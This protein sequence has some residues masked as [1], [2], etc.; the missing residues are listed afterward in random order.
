MI[1]P[2]VLIVGLALAG[3]GYGVSARHIAGLGVWLLV[4]G[5]LALGTA[6][7]AAFARPFYWA[8][9]LLCGLALL[10]ALSSL[11]SGSMELSV[12]EADR[13]LVYLG[14]FL[15]AFLIAQTDERRQRFAEGIAIAVTLV[16][17]LGLASR[18]LPEILSVGN[19]L[20]AG[21]RLR[22]PLGYWNANG[23]MFGIA[24][25]LLLWSSRRS[26]FAALRWAAVAAMPAVLLALY[27]TYS[28]GGLLS[29]LIA[30]GCLLAL[31]RDRLWMLATLAIGAIGALPAVL[32]VQARRSL[33]DSIA[34]QAAVDQ[35]LTVLLILLAGTA[36][37]LALFAGLR[38]LERREGRLTGHA[39]RLSQSP[40]LL[41]RLAIAA[42]LIAIGVVIAVGGR[43]WNQFSSSDLQFPNQPEKHFGQLSGAGRHDFY[44]VAVDSFGEKPLL[45]HGAGTYEFSW[46]RLRSIDIP[47]HNAH[48]LY[49]EAFSELGLVGG[50]VV[51]GLFGALLWTGFGAWRAAT[52]SQRELCAALLAAMA[53]FA[54]GAAFDWFW[55][56]AALG[57]VFF[58]A[59]G[60]LV[61]VRCAQLSAGA[62]AR[63]KGD[64]RR[65]G[66]AVS[67]LILAWIAAIGLVGPLLVQH[68]LKSSQ[69][70]AADGDLASAVSHA[71]TARSIEPWAASPYVQ[72]GLLAQLQGEFPVASERL[73]QA[74]ERE[75]RNWQLYYLRSKVEHEAGEATR[76]RADLA[77]AHELNPLET[78]FQAGWNCG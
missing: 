30:A 53:A 72:L 28:R 52:G 36:L 5:L 61:A 63:R 39:V 26:S 25:A 58:L 43:A 7:R 40:A 49:L 45:G 55:E 69:H 46:E 18:L 77:K 51:L 64:E 70:A 9:G 1:A 31:S 29:L 75:D 66:L 4:V 73:S 78:C 3:G 17:F 47:V 34:K 10:S 22:Y 12:V 13:V 14:F 62:K 67:G 24:V 15:A 27:F 21:A 50:L 38:A 48:S 54:V 11:W 71:S 57:A 19:S 37:T 6:T 23:A 60:A 74:I 35:G 20:G 32:A 59:A 2:S 42:A 44:R 8:S 68:E 76:A 16:A 56:I 65:Y 41:K 33:A